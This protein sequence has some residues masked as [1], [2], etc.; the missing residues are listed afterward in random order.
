MKIQQLLDN[1]YFDEAKLYK[2]LKTLS[3]IWII[4]SVFKYGPFPFQ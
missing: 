2:R 4:W 3:V 1:N